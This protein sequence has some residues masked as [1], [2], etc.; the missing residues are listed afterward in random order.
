[1]KEYKY[2]PISAEID[3]I[4]DLFAPQTLQLEIAGSKE[5]GIRF[6][7]WNIKLIQDFQN[8]MDNF[9]LKLLVHIQIEKV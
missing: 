5:Y 9:Y 6:M 3:K 1:M 4:I 8:Q 7:I 2:K